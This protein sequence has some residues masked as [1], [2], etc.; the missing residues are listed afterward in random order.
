MKPYFAIYLIWLVWF[1]TWIAGALLAPPAFKRN[2]PSLDIL[3]KVLALAGYALL[4]GLYNRYDNQ[5]RLW[6]S[7]TGALGWTMVTIEFAAFALCWWARLQF[8]FQWTHDSKE[9]PT[10]RIVETGPYKLIRHPV[11]SGI[12]VAAAATAAVFGTPSAAAGVAILAG[13]FVLKAVLEEEAL[14]GELGEDAFATYAE[15]VPMVLPLQPSRLWTPAPDVAPRTT[16][17]VEAPKPAVDLRA[18]T[19]KAE[20]AERAKPEPAKPE[21]PETKIEEIALDLFADASEEK[22]VE[23]KPAEPEPEK[24]EDEDTLDLFAPSFE[25]E[26]ADGTSGDPDH[27]ALSEAISITKR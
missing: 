23:A 11:Y 1:L 7:L 16:A 14:R 10:P 21:T 2:N 20:V 27:A 8:G 15:R 17:K 25:K 18:A 22:P 26:Q 5:Y 12:V 19:A 6:M 24:E 4:F 3:T 13:A 9:Q